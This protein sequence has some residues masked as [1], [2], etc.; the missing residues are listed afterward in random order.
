MLVLPTTP[1]F[2]VEVETNKISKCNGNK[3]WHT[4]LTTTSEQKAKAELERLNKEGKKA[5]MFEC[6]F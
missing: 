1:G 6:I 5:R 4:T 3:I 2:M